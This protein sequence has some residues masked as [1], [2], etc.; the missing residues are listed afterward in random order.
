MS[1]VALV[2]GAS[3]GIGKAIAE[4]LA[5]SGALTIVNYSKSHA[6][7][8]QVVEEIRRSGGKAEAICADISDEKQ[9][10]EMFVRIGEI[11]PKLD[12]LVN[13][14]GID[15][16][17]KLETYEVADWRRIFDVNVAGKL[18]VIKHAL[19]YLKQS[20]GARVVN[21]ASPL[22]WRP[23]AE[24]S[25]YCCSEAAI[26]MLTKCAALELAPH[27]IRVNTICPGFTRTSMNE[28]IYPDKKFWQQI[29]EENP[30]KRIAEPTDIAN[31]VMFLLSDQADYMNGAELTLDGGSSLGARTF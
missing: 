13:N 26:V 2:T 10:V 27:G 11:S 21:V 15:L 23:L 22:A 6:K 9:V 5:S 16:P 3:Q 19:P 20:S 31:A 30:L 28:A 1:K 4:Q 8:E 17:Q 29:A 24:A 14:A 25:A 12:Y 7:A 18:L